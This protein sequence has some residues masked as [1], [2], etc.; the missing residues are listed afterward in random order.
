METG[1]KACRP[2][3]GLTEQRPRPAYRP[4][5]LGEVPKGCIT[6][7]EMTLD[8][9]RAAKFLKLTVAQIQERIEKLRASRKQS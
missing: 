7:E 9:R 5:L 1:P 3:R 6:L 4:E 2:A 8:E